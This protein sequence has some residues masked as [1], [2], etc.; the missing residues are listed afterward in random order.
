MG[1]VFLLSLSLIIFFS[2]GILGLMHG[3]TPGGYFDLAH[4][5]TAGKCLLLRKNPYEIEI[6]QKSFSETIGRETPDV[7][8]YPPQFTPFCIFLALFNLSTARF[9][10]MAVNTVSI[11]LLSLLTIQIG[12]GE[13]PLKKFGNRRIEILIIPIILLS[14]PSAGELVWLGQ[15]SFLLMTCALYS[16]LLYQRENY[17]LC[18]IL[19]GIASCKPQYILLISLWL[20]LEKKWLSLLIAAI[21]AFFLSLYSFWLL[22]GILPTLDSWLNA[23]SSYQDN[24]VNA[25][26]NKEVVG[27]PSLLVGTGL[28]LDSTFIWIIVAGILTILVWTNRFRFSRSDY[29]GIIFSIHSLLIYI[30]TS[31]IVLWMA[32]FLSAF[33]IYAWRDR[34][35]FLVSCPA[36][37]LLYL[38]RRFVSL[39][40]IPFLLHW[41]TFCIFFL[42]LILIIQASKSKV[43]PNPQAFFLP[44]RNSITSGDSQGEN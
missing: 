15:F 23:L 13:G 11:F 1:I 12:L 33:L 19:L 5:Y 20:L 8:F 3:G 29:L 31:E 35:L 43:V 36:I 41:R 42:F 4:F 26:G 9:I 14:L 30:K 7:F 17:I 34:K 6:F 2:I 25:L 24:P 38:P 39:L 37:A 28:D 10:G 40:D 44:L 16:W 21:T 27:I 22:G 18:G 32:T